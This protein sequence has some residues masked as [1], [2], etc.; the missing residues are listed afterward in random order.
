[1]RLLRKLSGEDCQPQQDRR[2][3][4]SQGRLRYNRFMTDQSPKI[5]TTFQNRLEM[6]AAVRSLGET[7]S[8]WELRQRAVEVA[9]RYGDKIL[10]ALV[11]ALDTSNPQLRGGLGH[12]TKRLDK[13]AA[14]AALR[15]AALNR[16]LSDQARLTAITILEGFREV[17]PDDAMYAGMAAPEQ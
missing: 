3:F 9:Q 16:T 10:P 15:A 11:G 5:I 13:D 2:Q 4:I 14:V 6:E 7:S 8:D 1:M 17:P 12:L